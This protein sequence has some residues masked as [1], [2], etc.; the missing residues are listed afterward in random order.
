M[1]HISVVTGMS[2]L[3]LGVS[4]LTLWASKLTL[5]VSKLILGV[6]ALGV[7]G[8]NARITRRRSPGR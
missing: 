2:K 3:I 4:T 7:S 1:T 8:T 5:G 6:S